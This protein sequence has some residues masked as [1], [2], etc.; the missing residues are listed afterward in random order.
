M[1]Q[2]HYLIGIDGILSCHKIPRQPFE[3]LNSQTVHTQRLTTQNTIEFAYRMKRTIL[4]WGM[5]CSLGVDSAP[6]AAPSHLTTDLIEHTDRVWVD[7]YPSQIGLDQIGHTLGRVQYVAI[8]SSQPRFGWQLEESQPNV[9]QTACRIEVA[10]SLKLLTADSADLWQS[11]E[12]ITSNQSSVAY[13]GKALQPSKV[14]YW[15]VA[16][17]NN[18]AWQPWSAPRAFRTADKLVPYQNAYYPIEKCDEEPTTVRRINRHIVFVDFGRAAFGQL[19]LTLTAL[20]ADTLIVRLGE[21]IRDG[22]LDRSPGGSRRFLQ[23]VVPLRAGT[24]TYRLTIPPDGRNTQTMAIRMPDYIGEVY[25][26]RYCELEGQTLETASE[27]SA[28]AHIV[29]HAVHYP[30]NDAASTFHCSDTTLNRVWELCKYSIKATSFTGLYIDGDRERIPYEGDALINQLGHY[31]TDR[32]FAMARRSHEYLLTHATWPTEWILQSVLIAWND[33]LYTGDDRSLRQNYDLLRAKTLQTLADEQ[34]FIRTTRQT[35]EINATIHLNYGEKIRDIVDWPQSGIVGEGKSEPGEADGYVFKEV[36]TV[37]NA[38]HYRALTL[39]GQIST[40]LGHNDDATRYHNDAARLLKN[41]NAA[42]YD[43]Q[44]GAYR[45]GI[46]TDHHALHAS[47]MPLAFGMV[48]ARNQ[49]A[50]LRFIRSRGMACSVFGAQFLLDGLYS[51]SDASY[52]LQLLASDAERSWYN[53]IRVGSTITL[54]AWDDKYKPNEDWNHAW[55]AAPA[56]L[57]VRRLM[58]IEPI[59]AGFGRMQIKPQPDTLTHAELTLPTIRGTVEVAF[60]NHPQRFA[61]SVSLPAGTTADILLPLPNGIDLK[62]STLQADGQT[63]R[64]SP[65]QGFTRIAHVGSGTHTITLDIKHK[66]NR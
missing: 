64:I 10:S 21:C 40:V 37:V 32:E 62:R 23:Q 60:D 47:M 48:E 49:P 34:G 46:G 20:H 38:Y 53:M 65:E 35:P 51:A 26:F 27:A 31:A 2:G 22:R 50:V 41:F 33:Y 9:V 30:F 24:H 11:G 15:R 5:L 29:R 43:S 59:E 25:P 56:N 57:I 6:C 13:E 58:G 17:R 14:Y 28:M 66:N 45:D 52:A 42:L 18:T 44:A 1:V 16:T 12:I 7:G 63:V 19:S 8:G 61:M 39:L 4:L 55:G 3:T 36:N 54:E